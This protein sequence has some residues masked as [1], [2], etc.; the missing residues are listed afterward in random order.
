MAD[1]KTLATIA[2][3]D[4]EV[5]LE[6]VLCTREAEPPLIELRRLSRG[7]GVGWFRQQTLRLEAVEA[8]RLLSTLRASRIHWTPRPTPPQTAKV[9]P[10]PH[11]TD[12][13]RDHAQEAGHHIAPVVTEPVSPITTLQ[14]GSRGSGILPTIWPRRSNKRE[15]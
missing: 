2:S 15:F 1:E 4:P 3:S 11:R 13:R 14:V 7:E 12:Q 5:L 9:I 8:E 10:F 6:V